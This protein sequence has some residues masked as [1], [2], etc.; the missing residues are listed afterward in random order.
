MQKHKYLCAHFKEGCYWWRLQFVFSEDK[1]SP[2]STVQM[3]FLQHSSSVNWH[4]RIGVTSSV[5]WDLRIGVNSHPNILFL[6]YFCLTEF[7]LFYQNDVNFES[8]NSLKLSFTNIWGVHLNFVY[9]E[10]FSQSN[11]ADILALCET[12][13]DDSIDSGNFSLS[14]YFL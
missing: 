12:N 9:Y 5:N 10:T 3:K 6:T 8:N 2:A 4:L 1:E 11:T 14:G 13:L 7:W